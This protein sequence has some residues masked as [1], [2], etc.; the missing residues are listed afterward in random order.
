MSG[1]TVSPRLSA[2]QAELVEE[3]V[4]V[5]HERA[6]VAVRL[7]AAQFD[8]M[9]G[10]GHAAAPGIAVRFDPSHGT[11]LRSYARPRL[12]WAMF[13]AAAQ[14]K[15][16]P[17]RMFA[18]L[19]ELSRQGDADEQE[20][21]VSLTALLDS[22]PPRAAAV[23]RLQQKAGAWL[24]TLIADAPPDTEEDYIAREA[25]ALALAAL[26]AAV[27]ELSPEEQKLVAAFY[28]EKL[29]IDETAAQLCLTRPT[30]RRLHDAV[31][32]KLAISL[33]HRG[34]EGSR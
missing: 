9:V 34:V 17:S 27:A 29:T 14:E 22:P 1:A 31:K 30:T 26:K 7:L 5:I 20:E 18:R 6:R 16:A 21:P 12:Q 13:E 3:L 33:R 15:R 11:P 8:D 19:A 2:Q 10:A 4:P 28:Y 23:A 32:K 24:A 25:H